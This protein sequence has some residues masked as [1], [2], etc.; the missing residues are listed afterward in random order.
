MTGESGRPLRS[1]CPGNLNLKPRTC[2]QGGTGEAEVEA[3]ATVHNVIIVGSGP[4][5]VIRGNPRGTRELK[6]VPFLA[7]SGARRLPS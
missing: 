6:L 3:D 1:V 2:H 7:S 5:A 4:M